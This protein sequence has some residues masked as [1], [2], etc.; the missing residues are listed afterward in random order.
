M[1]IN[2]FPIE[3]LSV[4]SV[5]NDSDEFIVDVEILTPDFEEDS[6]VVMSIMNYY[7]SHDITFRRMSHVILFEFFILRS[8]W[9]ATVADSRVKKCIFHYKDICL[10]HIHQF[11]SFF[12]SDSH[13]T[14]FGHKWFFLRAD[15]V[16]MHS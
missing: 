15:L 1:T 13:S 2:K 5:C 3:K 14:T 16:G 12:I 8:I 10:T 9:L 11:A 6:G 4:S 7:T